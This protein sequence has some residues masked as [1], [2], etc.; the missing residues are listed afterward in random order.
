MQVVSG[1]G[2]IITYEKVRHILSKNDINDVRLKGLI[3]GGIC[4]PKLVR[5]TLNLT[6]FPVARLWITS[7]SDHN[8][9]VLKIIIFALL[10]T[11]I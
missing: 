7:Q 9:Y 5:L 4:V 3:A 6:P 8:L 1:F 2:Y 10:L 11:L